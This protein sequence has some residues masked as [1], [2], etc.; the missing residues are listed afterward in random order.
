VTG[1]TTFVFGLIFFGFLFGMVAHEESH[2]AA[3]LI[4]RFQVVSFSLTHVTYS[5]PASSNYLAVL[6]VQLAGGIGESIFSLAS[7]RLIAR[8]EGKPIPIVF[9]T[10]KQMAI[11]GLIFGSELSLLTIAFH[12]GVT[13]VWEGLFIEHYQQFHNDPIMTVLIL[14]LCIIISLFLVVRRYRRL[15]RMAA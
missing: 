6:A 1:Y 9:Q 4:F 11:L 15:S 5:Y 10:R 12:G 7:F 2:A 8:N 3:C 14:S 13:A